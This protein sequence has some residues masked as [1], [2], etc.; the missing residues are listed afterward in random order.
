MP[1][2]IIKMASGRSEELKTKLAEEITK[3]IMKHTGN[4][5]DEVSVSIEDIE[6]SDWTEKVYNK[7]IVPTWDKLYKKP[8]YGPD[9]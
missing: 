8:G 3:V 7:D 1:H 2:V 9:E 4:T 5:K 6:P